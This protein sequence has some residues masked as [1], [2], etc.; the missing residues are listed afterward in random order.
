LKMFYLGPTV[1]LAGFQDVLPMA[2]K[3]LNMV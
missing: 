2:L 1:V 3:L